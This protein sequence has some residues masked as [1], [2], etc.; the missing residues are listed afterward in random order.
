M[1][2]VRID[3]QF[4]DHPKVLEAGPQG[5]WLY[6]CGLTYAARYLTDGFIPDAAVAKLSALPRPERIAEELVRSGLWERAER[7]FRIHD[8]L[9]Y[10]PSAE[11]VRRDR[12]ATATRVS[13]H[14]SRDS[15]QFL[16]F[17]GGPSNAVTSPVT[18]GVTEPLVTTAPGNDRPVPGPSPSPVLPESEYVTR[19]VSSEGRAA[20]AAASPPPSLVQFDAILSELRG[21]RPDADFY[22]V[23]CR[24]YGHLNLEQEAIKAREHA[25]KKHYAGDLKFVLGWLERA[26]NPPWPTGK[27]ERNGTTRPRA[28][29]PEQPVS[30]LAKYSQ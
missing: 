21:Y 11:K 2:W 24:D 12:A 13:N 19:S 7:G 1:G 20:H 23:V 9:V 18:N 3:D 4:T 22:E 5:G 25:R 8:Y 16:P 27:D 10:N 26:S 6:V 15:G 30:G 17:E 28:D 29:G 14:R